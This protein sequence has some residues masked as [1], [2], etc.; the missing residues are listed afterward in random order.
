MIIFTSPDLKPRVEAI[1]NGK[2]T[3]VIVID[4]K[5]KNE[6]KA[7]FFLSQLVSKRYPLMEGNLFS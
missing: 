5:R 7:S 6:A 2:P 3:T 1:R 4:I